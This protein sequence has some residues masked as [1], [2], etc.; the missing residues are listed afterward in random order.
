MKR[1]SRIGPVEKDFFHSV[2][3]LLIRGN[4]W[5]LRSLFLGTDARG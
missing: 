1:I 2:R 4:P 5:L 3:I